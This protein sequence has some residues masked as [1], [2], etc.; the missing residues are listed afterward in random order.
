[1]ADIL[2]DDDV[3]KLTP[4]PNGTEQV[5]RRVFGVRGLLLRVGKR[6]KTFELRAEGERPF[7][8]VLGEHPAIPVAAAIATAQEMWRR[9]DAKPPLPMTP[10]PRM[11]TP[12][13]PRCR[14]SKRG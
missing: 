5:F 9:H 11:N 1:M 6:K 10:P 8:R 7:R 14:C 13:Q 2:T 3:K 12:S 4:R